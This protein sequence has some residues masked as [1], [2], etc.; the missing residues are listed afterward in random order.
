MDALPAVT[1]EAANGAL[2]RGHV[3]A[4]AGLD[5]TE[6]IVVPMT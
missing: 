6:D 1:S 5:E 4:A 2:Q 3:L